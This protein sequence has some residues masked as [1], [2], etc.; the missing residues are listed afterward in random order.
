MNS[1]SSEHASSCHEKLFEDSIHQIP[2]VH[3]GVQTALKGLLLHVAADSTNLGISGPIF[4]DD[5][6]KYIP[7]GPEYDDSTE[8]LTY[9]NLDL[10]AYIP[11]E[12]DNLC[13]HH[14][15]N[16]QYFTYGEPPD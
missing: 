4:E 1:A 15:P 3:Q 6:F 13:P 9:H 5:T 10:S 2:R 16:P 11:M 8:R 12:F 14:D 7:L